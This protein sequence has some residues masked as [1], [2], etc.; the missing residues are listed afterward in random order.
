MGM[1]DISDEL[2]DLIISMARREDVHSVSCQFRDAELWKFLM[3]EQVRRAKDQGKSL[4]WKRGWVVIFIFPMKG[5]VAP[6][7]S[8]I[9]LGAR[10]IQKRGRVKAR[11]LTRQPR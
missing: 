9:Q 5:Y 1:A 7:C 6:T 4:H 2:R 11:N 8:F 10:F 3:E